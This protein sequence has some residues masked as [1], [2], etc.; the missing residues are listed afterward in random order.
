VLALG[1]AGAGV[2]F[3]TR[4]DGAKAQQDDPWGDGS[5]DQVQ[6]EQPDHDS[7]DHP[8]PEEP[9]EPA[10]DEAA[11]TKPDPWATNDPSG[12]VPAVAARKSRPAATIGTDFTPLP[13]GVKITPPA[14]FTSTVTDDAHV[15]VNASS[16]AMIALTPLLPGTN[17]PDELAEM[18]TSSTGFARTKSMKV[19]S[20][21]KQRDAVAFTG[22]G[23]S[24]LIVLYIEPDYRVGILYQAP[25]ATFARPAFQRE[26][27]NFLEHGVGLP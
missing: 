1:G 3:A 5:G 6:P 26:M 9:D 21:G 18:W 23:M 8:D 20:A 11:P 13:A 14:G 25:S 4:D 19:T 7:P 2:W 17:D 15:Y 24:Q 16:A 12:G 10:P 22:N 27:T